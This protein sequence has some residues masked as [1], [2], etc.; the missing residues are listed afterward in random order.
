MSQLS[1]TTITDPHD[2]PTHPGVYQYWAGDKLLYIGKAVSLRARLLSHAQNAKLDPKEAAV[3]YGADKIRYT[4]TDNDF[5]ALL[6]ESQLIGKYQPPY[7]LI[8]K[9]GRSY[10]YISIDMN[11]EFPKPR[12]VRGSDLPIIHNSKSIIHNFGPFPST[13]VAEEILKA[14]RRLVP[15]CTQKGITKRQCFH[16]HVGLC[17]PCPSKVNELQGEEREQGVLEYRTHVRQII[18]ILQGKTDPVIESLTMRMTKLSERQDYEEA[19]NL[20]NKIERFQRWIDT[21][22]FSDKRVLVINDSEAKLESLKLLLSQELPNLNSLHRIE[23]YD[24]SNLLF[25]HSV[26]SMVVLTDGR[27]DKSQYRR[28]KIK[29]PRANSDFTRLQEALTRRFKNKWDSPNLLIIDG[30]KPQVRMALKV[31][32]QLENPPLMLGLAKAPDRL[33]I[34]HTNNGRT[35]LITLS[36]DQNHPGFNLLKLLRDESHRFA[37]SYREILIKKSRIYR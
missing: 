4:L 16:S 14:I 20:R 3:V 24:A 21:H 23:C 37:N 8:A 36:P 17:N 7:N 33:I 9:D 27:I 12:L 1:W 2:A 5:F 26:V 15:Y 11:D 10:L 29:N 28:F 31:M 34:P 35:T 32:D 30:G 25:Q 18:K 6:L 13:A 22:S 19:L